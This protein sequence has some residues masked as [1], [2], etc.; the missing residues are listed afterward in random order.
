MHKLRLALVIYDHRSELAATDTP[1][2]QPFTILVYVQPLLTVMSIHD[3]RTLFLFQ[4]LLPMI[5]ELLP[6]RALVLTARNPCLQINRAHVHHVNWVLVFQR[7]VRHEAG[8]HGDEGAEIR[9][10]ADA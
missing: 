8:V 9:D 3:G 2:I 4:L 6:R 5:P 7:D 10:M 1:G